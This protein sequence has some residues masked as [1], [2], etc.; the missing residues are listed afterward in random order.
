[1]TTVT[2]G[3]TAPWIG[4]RYSRALVTK[5]Q[6]SGKTRISEIAS[7]KTKCASTRKRLATGLCPSAMRSKDVREQGPA[8]CGL[9][10]L[11]TGEWSRSGN[12]SR[13][14]CLGD[15]LAKIREHAAQRSHVRTIP[16]AF[17]P[18]LQHVVG[19]Q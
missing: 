16:L 18:S 13:V 11:R 14:E 2:G 17:G 3:P 8:A 7:T 5:G 19:N 15:A 10:R 6:S 12:A 1:M 9:P 4:E